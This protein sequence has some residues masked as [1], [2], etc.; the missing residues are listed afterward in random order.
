[1]N[2][3]KFEKVSFKQ[4]KYDLERDVI[5]WNAKMFTDTEIEDMY[6]SIKLPQRST[7]GSAGFDF[8]A[9]Y[10]Q[11]AFKDTR[12]NIMLTGIKAK[13]PKD[14]VLILLP[15][16]SLAVK[17]SFTLVNTTGVID[18]DYYNNEQNEGHIKCMYRAKNL[19]IEKGDKFMQGIFLNYKTTNEE[20]KPEKIRDGGF[21]STGRKGE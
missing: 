13:M 3:I 9:P 21:G 16:S 6:Y 7:K 14:V 1:M 17:N 12:Y 19:L 15:R 8:F 2:D 10:S 20:I 4:F 5:K 18:S 11:K